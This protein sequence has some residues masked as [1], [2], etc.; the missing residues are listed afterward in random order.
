[1][2]SSRD[3]CVSLCVCVCPALSSFILPFY[4]KL[5]I[6]IFQKY[7]HFSSSWLVLELVYKPSKNYCAFPQVKEPLHT[8]QLS[9]LAQQQPLQCFYTSV[10][11]FVSLH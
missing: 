4:V 7:K 1:M 9:H 8:S 11:H 5:V 10:A 3:V 2:A 6:P